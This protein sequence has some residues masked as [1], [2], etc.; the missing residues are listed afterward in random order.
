MGLVGTARGSHMSV[1]ELSGEMSSSA[2]LGW[3]DICSGL[4]MVV[5]AAR[6]FNSW[7]ESGFSS[8]E[9]ENSSN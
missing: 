3:A 2:V 7:H 1:W 4:V 9:K 5:A 8:S 6:K